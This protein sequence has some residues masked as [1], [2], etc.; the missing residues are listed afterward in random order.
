[1]NIC[2]RPATVLQPT[3]RA[4]CIPLSV[5]T[6]SRSNQPPAPRVITPVTGNLPACSRCRF[7]G[8]GLRRACASSINW[9]TLCAVNAEPGSRGRQGFS[10]PGDAPSPGRYFQPGYR[11]RAGSTADAPVLVRRLKPG[12]DAVSQVDFLQ[13]AGKFRGVVSDPAGPA[14]STYSRSP[15]SS[16]VAKLARNAISPRFSFSPAPA[17]STGPRLSRRLCSGGRPNMR[18]TPLCV[19]GVTPGATGSTR[20]CTPRPARR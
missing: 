2:P 14:V 18:P 6:S 8:C 17:A 11:G 15:L 7:K 16:S 5:N 19:L 3:T 1:M 13:Q 12:H 9:L 4:A 20:P 10:Q